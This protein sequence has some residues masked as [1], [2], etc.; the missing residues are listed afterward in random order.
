MTDPAEWEALTEALM[1]HPALSGIGAGLLAAVHLGLAR[2]SRRFAQQ[3]GLSHALVMREC[4]EL[5]E[6]GL[7]VAT[8]PEGRA[9]RYDLALSPAG[10]AAMQAASIG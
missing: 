10:L 2:D 3:F 1:T 4:A 8:M 6:R 7:I 5:A 9:P